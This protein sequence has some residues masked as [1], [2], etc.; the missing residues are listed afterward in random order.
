[1]CV[2]KVNLVYNLLLLVYIYIY[3][4]RVYAKELYGFK[5]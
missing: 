5:S 1:M 2:N 4:Y 3:M